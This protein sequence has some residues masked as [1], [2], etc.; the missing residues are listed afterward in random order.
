MTNQNTSQF[1]INFEN[2]DH[3]PAI[4]ELINQ[5]LAKPIFKNVNVKVKEINVK[6]DHYRGQERYYISMSSNIHGKDFFIKETG[7]DM[8]IIID[9]L[10]DVFKSKLTKLKTSKGFQRLTAIKYLF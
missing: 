2:V 10:F 9:K 5:K 1:N 8:T 3:S 6:R 4:V 7:D